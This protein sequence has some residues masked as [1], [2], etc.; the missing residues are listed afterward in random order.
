LCVSIELSNLSAGRSTS[1]SPL[2]AA[3]AAAAVSPTPAAMHAAASLIL[4]DNEYLHSERPG[5]EVI[6]FGRFG[7]RAAFRSGGRR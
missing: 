4:R 5:G 3:W 2:G 1:S 6:A 7:C